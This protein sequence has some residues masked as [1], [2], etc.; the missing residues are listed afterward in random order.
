MPISVSEKK[1]TAMDEHLHKIEFVSDS[2][3]K[4]QNLDSQIEY[5]RTMSEWF[6]ADYCFINGITKEQAIAEFNSALEGKF[7]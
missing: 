1:K 4:C 3:P 2:C 6:I 7:K 5:Y